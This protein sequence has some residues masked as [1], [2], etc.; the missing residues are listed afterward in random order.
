MKSAEG[1]TPSAW[2]RTG[3]SDVPL[4]QVVQFCH[5]IVEDK[6][7]LFLGEMGGVF[8]EQFLGIGPCG[9]TV[10]EIIG[11][12]QATDIAEVLH[13]EGDPIV[14]EGHIDMLTKILTR[15]FRQSPGG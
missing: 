5:V 13:L 15:H 8:F 1:D 3:T 9:V 6:V 10:G 11:P 2:T 12:H 4:L 7:F 14:L